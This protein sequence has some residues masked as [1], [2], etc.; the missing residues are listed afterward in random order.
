MKNATTPTKLI[1]QDPMHFLLPSV[2]TLALPDPDGSA[3]DIELLK[4]VPI[5]P[6]AERFR[7]P[8]KV[9]GVETDKGFVVITA[10]P[11]KGVKKDGEI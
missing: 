5:V 2:F 6:I 9:V 4:N 11:L 7:Y 1:I 10:Y 3:R 8:L